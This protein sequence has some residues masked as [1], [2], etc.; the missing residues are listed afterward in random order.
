MEASRAGDVGKGFAVV[1][2]AV[3]ETANNARMLSKRIEDV[4][5]DSV[6][7]VDKIDSSLQKLTSRQSSHYDSEIV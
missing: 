6:E 4:N 3:K 2:Q 1:A 7:A 5:K